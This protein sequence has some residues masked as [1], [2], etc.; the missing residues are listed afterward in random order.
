METIMTQT[1]T[2][3]LRIER[4]FDAPI[5]LVWRCWTEKEHLDKWSAPNGFSIP[6]SSGDARKGGQY[7]LTMRT[8][9]GHDLGLGGVYREIV[10]RKLLVMTHVWDED[11]IETVVTVRFEDLGKRTRMIFE[12]SGFDS[13]PSRKGHEEGWTECFDKL[14]AMLAAMPA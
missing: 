2:R 13:E 12:Q 5:D 1:D 10:P 11:G 6:R 8:P 4:V 14:D 9:D 3:V 7:H